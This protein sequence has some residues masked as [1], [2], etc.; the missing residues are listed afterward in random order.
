MAAARATG[1]KLPAD[2]LPPA[3]ETPQQSVGLGHVLRGE[4]LRR[5]GEPGL[6]EQL[7][8][9]GHSELVRSWVPQEDEYIQGCRRSKKAVRCP[10]RYQADAGA[11]PVVSLCYRGGMAMTLRTDAELDNALTVLAATEGAS[12]QEIIRRAVL[13]RYERSAHASRVRD[14][15]NRMIN[16][17]ADVIERLRAT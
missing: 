14:S 2:R 1:L 17:W 3:F 8:Q 12:R 10:R 5:T 16:Q 6:D 15:S 4:A 11:P 9:V 7:L 13:D